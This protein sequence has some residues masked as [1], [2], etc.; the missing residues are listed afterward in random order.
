MTRAKTAANGNRSGAEVATST[1]DSPST[2][3]RE[4]STSTTPMKTDSPVKSTEQTTSIS[5][6]TKAA[7]S[8]PVKETG[9][10]PEKKDVKAAD[11]VNK[12]SETTP[13][14]SSP[15]KAQ[16]PD[17]SASTATQRKSETKVMSPT[18]QQKQ[19]QQSHEEQQSSRSVRDA[20]KELDARHA[21]DTM[22]KV[23]NAAAKSSSSQKQP[24]G[25][26]S[27][28]KEVDDKIPTALKWAATPGA[29]AVQVAGSF[30]EWK[31]RFDLQK[32]PDG[33]F[34]GS[35]PLKKG[36]YAVK[37]I[38]DGQWCYDFTAPNEPDQEGNVNNII[39]V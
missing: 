25:A 17:A 20:A 5:S 21:E 37:Y 3:S 36:K 31:G 16:T 4:S 7:T 24:N 19:Q 34:T 28:N 14:K 22:S 1:K 15:A 27:V 6:P 13:V 10:T 8:S 38:V 39:E 2:K 11:P 23:K 26:A 29:S 35:I 30:D 9:Y 32:G 18:D 12:P 33:T